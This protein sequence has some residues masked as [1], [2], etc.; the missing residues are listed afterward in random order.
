MFFGKI[1]RGLF[2][3]NGGERGRVFF[4]VFFCEVVKGEK[5]DSKNTIKV[6][7]LFLFWG[8]INFFIIM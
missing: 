3:Y 6:C 2:W 4:V 7:V 8:F 5:K 1:D